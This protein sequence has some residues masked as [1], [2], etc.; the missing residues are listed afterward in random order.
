MP[1]LAD[2][3]DGY[4]IL[5]GGTPYVA[6]GT[7]AATPLWAGLIAR[8]SE[9]LG[10]RVPWLNELVYHPDAQAAFRPVTRGNNQIVPTNGIAFFAAA[11][12]WNACCGLGVPDG[13]RLATE[14][15][16]LLAS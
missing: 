2:V 9:R 5:V 8:L 13:E 14:L 4:R 11:P 16:G 3:T 7:S 15:E 6:G 10:V 1:A 12:G